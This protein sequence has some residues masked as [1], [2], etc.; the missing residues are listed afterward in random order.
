ML[1][2]VLH[3]ENKATLA[4]IALTA[5]VRLNHMKY[6]GVKSIIKKSKLKRERTINMPAE[7]PPKNEQDPNVYPNNNF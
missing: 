2:Q 4:F 1:L 7:K 5:I 3:K 6:I